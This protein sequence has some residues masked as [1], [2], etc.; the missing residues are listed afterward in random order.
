ML[1]TST[2]NAWE[3]LRG[4]EGRAALSSIGRAFSEVPSAE[5]R[6]ETNETSTSSSMVGPRGVPRYDFLNNFDRHASLT[7]FTRPDLKGPF[8]YTNWVSSLTHLLRS[9]LAISSSRPRSGRKISRLIGTV[10]PLQVNFWP[11]SNR[12]WDFIADHYGDATVPVEIS[13]G[14]GDYRDLYAPGWR[15]GDRQF[16]AGVPTKLA[17]LIDHIKRSEGQ[18][19]KAGADTWYLAQ[20]DIGQV[21]PFLLPHIRAPIPHRPLERLFRE[22][23]YRMSER[24]LADIRV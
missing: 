20:Q 12:D 23:T 10:N 14:G 19:G 18:Q 8:I 17:A 16:E 15:R 1:R 22:A 7:H 2:R 9:L 13:R 6:T 3:L 4:G 11:L 21:A 5:N 24:W